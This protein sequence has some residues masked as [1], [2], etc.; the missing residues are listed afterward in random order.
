[1][2]SRPNAV[3]GFSGVRAGVSERTV[4]FVPVVG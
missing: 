2:A 1:M 3:K 4:K